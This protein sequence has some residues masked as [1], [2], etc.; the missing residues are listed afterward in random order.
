MDGMI[1]PAAF[2]LIP[3]LVVVLLRSSGTLLFLS[4]CLGSVLATYVAGDA[5]SIISSA[6]PDTGETAMQWAQLGLLAIP[7]IA[8]AVLTR[9]RATSST[10]VIG[11]LAAA[12]AGALLM[13]L[14]TPFMTQT[15]QESLTSSELWVQ[16]DNLQT[17]I[18][19]A[20]A[21]L[22]LGELFLTRHRHEGKKKEH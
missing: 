12:T 8:T 6:T 1:L 4:V 20:G 17:S 3:V 10:L 5:S 9:K 2:V 15:L 11:I 19:I 16:L 13:L 21:L 22:V 7:V 14:V 18:V